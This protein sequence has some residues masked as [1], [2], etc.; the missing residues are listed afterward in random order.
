M[1]RRLRMHSHF[2][3]V[4]NRVSHHSTSGSS[5]RVIQRVEQFNVVSPVPV[6]TATFSYFTA[7]VR[8]WPKC[9]HLKTLTTTGL[10]VINEHIYQCDGLCNLQSRSTLRTT[11]IS[12]PLGAADVLTQTIDPLQA[13]NWCS[14]RA[15]DNYTHCTAFGGTT[16]S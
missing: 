11:W 8:N 4:R 14:V 16:H 9:T 10:V 7:A 6:S 1:L 12:R 3:S 5:L 15:D 13:I 2:R